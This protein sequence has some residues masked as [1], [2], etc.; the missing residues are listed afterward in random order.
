LVYVC[1]CN[2]N[3]VLIYNVNNADLAATITTIN[4]PTQAAFTLNNTP[5]VTGSNG[6]FTIDTNYTAT[7]IPDSPDNCQNIVITPNGNYAYFNTTSGSLYVID[8]LTNNKITMI[9]EFN[10]ET[11][12]T[13]DHM[14][15]SPDSNFIYITAN[16][17][18]ASTTNLCP[19]IY[20]LI[21]ID[22]TY[23]SIS[24]CPSQATKQWPYPPMISGVAIVEGQDSSR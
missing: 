8:I 22:N 2:T 11:D 1:C 13:I 18:P 14:I 12:Y 23:I 5:Y 4:G 24:Y 17:P 10:I 21:T 7:V 16:P 3:Q 15:A 9:Q 20:A 6:V 19:I